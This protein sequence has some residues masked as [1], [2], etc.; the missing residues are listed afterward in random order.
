MH[1][2]HNLGRMNEVPYLSDSLVIPILS[3][4]NPF[5]LMKYFNT[6]KQLTLTLNLLKEAKEFWYPVKN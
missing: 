2:S 1:Q 5:L 6:E 3:W 4:D